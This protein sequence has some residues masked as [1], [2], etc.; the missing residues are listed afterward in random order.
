[1]IAETLRN[2]VEWRMCIIGFL[3]SIELI[4]NKKIK[5]KKSANP[6]FGATDEDGG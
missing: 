5:S 1:M 6:R 3:K 2:L 4:L